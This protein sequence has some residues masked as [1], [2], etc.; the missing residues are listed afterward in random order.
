VLVVE[1][2]PAIRAL[3]QDV[4][5][6]SGYTVTTAETG[7]QALEQ[8]REQRPDLVLLDL[9]LP[10]MN[11]W[12]FLRTRERDRQLAT[13]PILVISALGP[14]GTGH[15]QELGAPV[16]LHKPFDVSELLA[17]VNRLCSGP[18]RQCAWC[19]QVMDDAGQFRLRSGRKLRWATH[20]ICPNCK[21]VERQELLT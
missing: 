16:F 19:G 10:G 14:T 13:V 1:D 8:M 17:E 7:D 12:M 3:L 20:G 18:I 21:E 11:G 9:M 15:A 6:D 5:R 4:L 2:D